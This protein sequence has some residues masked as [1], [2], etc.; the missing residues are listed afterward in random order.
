LLLPVTFVLSEL[1][2]DRRFFKER[3][4]LTL[5]GDVEWNYSK[6]NALK[7]AVPPDT[8][9]VKG[10]SQPDPSSS[11]LASPV[12]VKIKRKKI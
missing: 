9:A 2:I 5:S 12:D 7:S 11:R 8:R 4:G 1:V 10:L 3:L 6:E